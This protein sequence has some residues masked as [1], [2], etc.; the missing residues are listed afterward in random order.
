M[1]GSE[2]LDEARHH[3]HAKRGL[4][5]PWGGWGDR[6]TGEAI[7]D[8]I[9]HGRIDHYVLRP[10]E[11]PN[12]L[13]HHAI[14][15]MLLEW[16]EAQRTSPYTVHVVADSWAGRAYERERCWDAAPCRTCSA[17]PTRTPVARSWPRRHGE[18]LPLVAFPD[19]TVLI[20]Q[21]HRSR[22]G[23][24][25]AGGPGKDELDLVIVGAGPAGCRRPYTASEGFST[26]VVDEGGVGG[27]ASASPLIRNY[28]GFRGAQRSP[29][30][31]TGA[32]AGVGLR[33]ELRVH[34]ARDRARRDG[35]AL[36]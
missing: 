28:L 16:A 7:F 12:E 11:P 9:A 22:P 13:L 3:P 17:W 27:Q 32:R 33:R 2:L 31:S 19:G 15:V 36:S 21:Q 10:E 35:S 24:G 14:S 26:L 4:L 20:D 6:P 23:H 8:S 29:S 18:R 30:G 1:T 34:D 5:I 25:P